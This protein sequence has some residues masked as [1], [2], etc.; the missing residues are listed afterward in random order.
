MTGFRPV[1][2]LGT[3]AVVGWRVERAVSDVDGSSRT[4]RV[5]ELVDSLCNA[6]H[7]VD[8]RHGI[9]R[10]F[11]AVGV[12]VD[13][14]A[15]L[16]RLVGRALIDHGLDPHRL[17][18]VVDASVCENPPAHEQLRALCEL[19]IG[20][21]LDDPDV[22]GT[23]KA[24]RIGLPINRIRLQAP[25][26]DTSEHL[27][28][29]M[30]LLRTALDLGRRMGVTSVVVGIDTEEQLL[31]ARRCGADLGN[32]D[33][34]APASPTPDL[35]EHPAT[36]A[37]TVASI[38][39]PIIDHETARL[40]AL[41]ATGALDTPREAVFDQI[42][43]DAADA[44]AAPIAMVSLIDSDRE[45]FKA[46]IGI[47]DAEWPRQSVA[48]AHTISR[49][50][51]MSIPDLSMDRRFAAFPMVAGHPTLRFYVGAPIL[52]ST[53]H[54]IG[55]VCVYDVVPRS[56]PAGA[57]DTIRELARR[58]AVEL[59]LRSFLRRV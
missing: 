32:G 48:G 59:E 35:L 51:V 1:V 50:D 39:A 34:L 37:H 44:F 26:I 53:G 46:K 23:V 24:L 15:E 21:A 13:E 55:T 12:Q 11:V 57:I 4:D 20:V 56:P 14:L 30:I 19:Q 5:S 25:R 45:W 7:H 52:M 10:R 58:A 16:P 54:A 42:A 17:S 29:D 2:H 40:E 8:A 27:H 9:S 22:T 33:R 28:T 36:R 6:L 47:D 41:H 38:I 43:C 3:S 18:V 31:A 49:S